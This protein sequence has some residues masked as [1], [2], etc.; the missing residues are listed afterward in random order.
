LTFRGHLVQPPC[1]E[2]GYFQLKQVAQ[3]PAQPGLEVNRSYLRRL[4]LCNASGHLC[5]GDADPAASNYPCI[6][7][8]DSIPTDSGNMS[9]HVRRSQG[10]PA[11]FLGTTF[12]KTTFILK[13]FS[14][15]PA[16]F[17]EK[18][19]DTTISPPLLA[20]LESVC[21][22]EIGFLFSPHMPVVCRPAKHCVV[23]C[24]PHCV[25]QW[26]SFFNFFSDPVIKSTGLEAAE[27]NRQLQGYFQPRE[28]TG[29]DGESQ[30]EML[31][32]TQSMTTLVT[33]VKP[34]MEPP[35]LVAGKC[36]CVTACFPSFQPW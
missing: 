4:A 7:D 20:L 24:L 22:L 11:H 3:S 30:E 6:F 21:D 5:H 29:R 2:Q 31:N 17:L 27:I 36:S 32:K 15:H 16:P 25:V 10:S 33:S 35:S 14:V 9:M 13:K 34:F 12:S 1:S 23:T 28:H 18:T 19:V 8:H 26:Q